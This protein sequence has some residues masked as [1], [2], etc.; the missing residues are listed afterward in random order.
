MVAFILFCS[1]PF[2]C[3]SWNDSCNGVLQQALRKPAR[4]SLCACP[5]LLQTSPSQHVAAWIIGSYYSYFYLMEKYLSSV[6]FSTF[7]VQGTT[8]S[9]ALTAHQILLRGTGRAQSDRHVHPQS[10]SLN[11]K[12]HDGVCKYA[13]LEYN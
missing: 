10:A 5:S 3:V 1:S 13:T 2:S 9:F 12:E 11:C 8:C 6:A 7:T 4:K